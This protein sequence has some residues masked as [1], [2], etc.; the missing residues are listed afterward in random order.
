MSDELLDVVEDAV[1]DAVAE[2]TDDGLDTSADSGVDISSE[3]LDA[4]TSDDQ[5]SETAEVASPAATAQKAA[6]AG[7]D[8]SKK[9][10][11]ASQSVTGRENRIPYT[12][13]KKIVEKNER[14]TIARV[15]KELEDKYTPRVTEYET[16]VKDYE[17]RLER[18]AQ[19]EQILENDPKQFLSM[20]SNVPAYKPFFDFITKAAKTVQPQSEIPAVPD[21]MPQPDQALADGTSVYSMEGLQKLLQ[22]QAE[23]VEKRVT[24]QVSQR[25]APIEQEWRSQQEYARAVPVVQQQIAEARKWPQFVENEAEITAALQADRNL[26]LEGAYRQ[27][28]I[29]RFAADKTKIRT[30]VLDE[31]RKK[32]IGATSAPTAQARPRPAQPT[33]GAKRDTEDIIRDAIAGLQ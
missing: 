22:W 4:S 18:V 5:S 24:A 28:V 20:L 16:K 27:V 30:E 23:N 2:P 21:G 33:G 29:P 12:R 14:D 15:T 10:G 6:E 19:F 26:S 31:L 1:N 3:S 25:Y 8:F 32:P 17:G 13:V 7:D 9:F 11:I